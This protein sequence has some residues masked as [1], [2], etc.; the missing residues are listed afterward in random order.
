MKKIFFYFFT[1][2]I[3]ISCGNKIPEETFIE[4]KPSKDVIS[5]EIVKFVNDEYRDK[6]PDSL[7]TK[8]F[9]PKTD[10]I[11]FYKNEIYISYLAG[12][13]G[14]VEYGGDIEVENDTL[15]LKLV[16]I[17][18]MACTEFNI[19]R[20]VYKIRNSKN[21]QYKIAKRLDYFKN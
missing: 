16:R 5:F 15:F 9:D 17:N 13:T 3:I 8:N 7:F 11:K 12:L 6:R 4:F 18:N 2:L 1:A 21:L 10:T 19:G 20:L 14:C